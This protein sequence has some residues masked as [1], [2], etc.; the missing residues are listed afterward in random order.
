MTYKRRSKLLDVARKM[1]TLK[2]SIPGQPFDIQK[3]EAVN[4]LIKQPEVLTY[5]WNHIK[6][7]GY[8]EYDPEC[9]AWTGVDYEQD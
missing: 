1:P 3:S 9:R 5:L 2:H 8:V 4:W 7:S 6:Q